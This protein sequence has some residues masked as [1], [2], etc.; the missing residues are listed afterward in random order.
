MSRE[1]DA[2]SVSVAMFEGKAKVSHALRGLFYS[3]IGKEDAPSCL[4][5]YKLHASRQY[6]HWLTWHA[7]RLH[8]YKVKQSRWQLNP[9]H[10]PCS[11]ILPCKQAT[12]SDAHAPYLPPLHAGNWIGCF[13]IAAAVAATGLM[14]ANPLPSAV[15]VAK[16][17]LDPQ[18][19]F[20]RAILLPHWVL[21][22][23]A[24]NA[25]AS[26]PLRAPSLHPCQSRQSIRGSKAN[27]L[28]L[29]TMLTLP[30]LPTHDSSSPATQKGSCAC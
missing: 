16:T 11:P 29:D 3:F 26:L 1:A 20:V 12:G 27:F 14:A 30:P 6:V 17:S 25:L 23:A 22:S 21:S 2:R 13:G 5:K 15:A 4:A 19:A 8:L 24:G 18:T 9:F 7:V 28:A 10:Q